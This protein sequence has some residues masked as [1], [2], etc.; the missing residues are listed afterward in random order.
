MIRYFIAVTFDNTKLIEPGD[1]LVWLGDYAED[2]SDPRFDHENPKLM[3]RAL[4][5]PR[6]IFFSMLK[7]DLVEFVPEKELEGDGANWDF[8]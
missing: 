4:F 2:T 8:S 1:P 3:V 7:Q 5:D 6:G